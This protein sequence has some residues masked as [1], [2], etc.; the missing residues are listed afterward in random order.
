MNKR[1]Q[2]THSNKPVNPKRMTVASKPSTDASKPWP[3]HTVLP[4]RDNRPLA[5]IGEEVEESCDRLEDDRESRGVFVKEFVLDRKENDEGVEEVKVERDDVGLVYEAG[6]DDIPEGGDEEMPQRHESEGA[7]S[8]AVPDAH[9]SRVIGAGIEFNL[10]RPSLRK[11]KSDM[12]NGVVQVTGVS[13][14][15]TLKR[16]Y[17]VVVNT[18]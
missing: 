6:V 7:E 2:L 10:E 14:S 12:P 4:A 17:R 15:Q 11:A 16:R 9:R 5:G 18:A 1:T 3:R 8:D 13:V